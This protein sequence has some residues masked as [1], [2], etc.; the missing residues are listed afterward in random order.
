MTNFLH[1]RKMTW[2]L[3]VWSGYIA[4]WMVISGSGVAMVVMWW[5]T[6]MIVFGL[7][8]LASQPLFRQGRGLR[9]FLVRPAPGQWRVANLRRRYWATGPPRP[10]PETVSVD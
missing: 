5:V 7:L 9:G 10:L 1:W 2:A 8:W 4:T 6:G 3:L